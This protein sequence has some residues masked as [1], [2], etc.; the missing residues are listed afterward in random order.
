MVISKS[1]TNTQ[2]LETLFGEVHNL[3][4]FVHPKYKKRYRFLT[5]RKIGQYATQLVQVIRDSGFRR[6]V[7]AETGAS[8]LAFLCQ[9]LLADDG[10]DAP[11]WLYVKFP[12]EPI[13]NI[14]SILKFYLS[15]KELRAQLPVR[16]IKKIHSL[17]LQ[18]GDNK[19]TRS[20]KFISKNR[21][22]LLKYLCNIMPPQDFE[23]R[24]K[25]LVRLLKTLSGGKQNVSQQAIAIVFENT[26]IAKFLSEPFLYF[27]E[28][29]DSG[30]TLSSAEM[31]FGFFSAK[32][33]FK[34]LSYYINVPGAETLPSVAYAMFNADSQRQCYMAGAYPF[35]NRVDLIGYFY[36]LDECTFKK[37]TTE[38][39]YKKYRRHKAT[40]NT[41]QFLSILER[42]IKKYRLLEQVRSQCKLRQVSTFI[43]QNHVTRYLLWRLEIELS[44]RNISSEFL[45]LLWDMYG[46]I[47][48]PLPDSYHLDFWYGFTGLDKT[49]ERI[50]ESRSLLLEYSRYRQAIFFSV[51]RS[52]IK[53]RQSWLKSIKNNMHYEKN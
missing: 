38:D 46:P 5:N 24:K 49:T 12:R 23:P 25:P 31:Y 29:I 28:Y 32:P 14:F 48:S 52:C 35:E 34:L 42:L 11:R 50:A 15:N 41:E 47:W 53:R 44:G 18:S 45:W 30:T 43:G 8:P 19:K 9:K 27:D 13:K 36:Y 21:G 26:E 2:V 39:I 17:V 1:S 4:C 22:E 37:V 10:K 51:A 16:Q 33:E 7:V 20:A 3:T 6:I 40:K